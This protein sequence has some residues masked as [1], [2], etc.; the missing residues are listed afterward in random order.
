MG[1]ESHLK[2]G[3]EIRELVFPH[4][5]AMPARTIGMQPTS[6]CALAATTAF[7]NFVGK[8][9]HG[10]KQRNRQPSSSHRCVGFETLYWFVHP[11]V[12]KGAKC[13][14]QTLMQNMHVETVRIKP[15]PTPKLNNQV[16][17]RGSKRPP[18]G[19]HKLFSWRAACCQ[20]QTPMQKKTRL[21]APLVAPEWMQLGGVASG[22]GGPHVV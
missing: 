13:R 1:F 8:K 17:A 19:H 7:A 5:R 14:T 6:P 15:L 20:T 18:M 9:K 22:I 12:P 4:A 21:P 11:K 10:D 3:H 16:S 2:D